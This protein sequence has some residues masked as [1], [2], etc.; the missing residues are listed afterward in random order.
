MNTQPKTVHGI[1]SSI[2]RVAMLLTSN[3]TIINFDEVPDTLEK[4]DALAIDNGL[5]HLWIHPSCQLTITEN[6]ENY[7][8]FEKDAYFWPTWKYEKAIAEKMKLKNPLVSYFGQRVFQRYDPQTPPRKRWKKYV[9]FLEYCLWDWP[10]DATPR[11]ILGWITDLESRL[12][13][14]ISG[15]PSGVGLRY[16]RQLHSKKP[17]FLEPPKTDLSAIPFRKEVKPLIWHRIPGQEELSENSYLLAVDKNAAFP[18]AAQEEEFGYSEPEHQEHIEVDGKEVNFKTPGIWHIEYLAPESWRA[19]E[20][21]TSFML[22]PPISP[23]AEW[24]STPLVKLLIKIGYKVTFDECWTFP[25]HAPIFEKWVKN[26]WEIRQ[27]YEDHTAQKTSMK[28]IM[29]D[30]LGLLRSTKNQD[31]PVFR[32]DWNRTIVEGSRANVYYNILKHAESGFYPVMAQI[33]ALYY[34]VK[35]REPNAAIPGIVAQSQGLGGYKLKWCLPLNPE[36]HNLLVSPL[37]QSKKLQQL[38]ILAGEQ[39]EEEIS[40]I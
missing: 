18:R 39:K 20:I 12:K 25:D 34:L 38:N 11:M 22:P 2:S 3:G 14:S 16:L 30:L 21:S 9:I 19:C 33:D 35:F 7:K 8:A 4:L 13:V 23:S 24:I 26:L 5:T 15:S 10:K 31:S 27:S 1:L 29:N 17:H 37:A 40:W 32:P 6:D 36:V 28:Q